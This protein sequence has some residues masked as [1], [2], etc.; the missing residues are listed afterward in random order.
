ME[1]LGQFMPFIFLIAIMYFVII[2]PQQQ[3]A[4]KKKEMIESLKK[5]DKIVTSGGF[6]AEVYKVEESFFKIKLNDD[7]IVKLE[8]DFVLRKFGDEA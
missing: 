1:I 7:T 6:I 2:R 5:G 8:K 3:E 4:K